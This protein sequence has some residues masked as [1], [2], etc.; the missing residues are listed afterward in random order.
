MVS[1]KWVLQH[2]NNMNLF[3]TV[4]PQVLFRRS[5]STCGVA[6]NCNSSRPKN[7][8]GFSTVQQKMT[9]KAFYGSSTVVGVGGT[10]TR[11]ALKENKLH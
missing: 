5:L 1:P 11:Q 8:S 3:G 2:N 10:H 6:T 7:S 9:P 4:S